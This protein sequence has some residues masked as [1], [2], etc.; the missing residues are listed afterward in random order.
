MMILTSTALS[1]T[2]RSK[3][4][5]STG[6]DPGAFVYRLHRD[7]CD[8]IKGADSPRELDNR[9]GEYADQILA[10]GLCTRCKPR[11]AY[12]DTVTSKAQAAV[13]QRAAVVQATP[14]PVQEHSPVTATYRDGDVQGL[15]PST[16]PR[17]DD[18][19]ALYCAGHGTYHPASKFN[20]IVTRAE[21]RRMAECRKHWTDRL[22]QRKEDLA[23]GRT[24]APAPKLPAERVAPKAKKGNAN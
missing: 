22:A 7:T 17:V 8:R 15:T 21:G 10:A 13:D 4:L 9:E 11:G 18:D 2:A 12:V 19:Q 16:Y 6:T 24:P 14:A 20:F 1:D 23:A 3:A 5:E